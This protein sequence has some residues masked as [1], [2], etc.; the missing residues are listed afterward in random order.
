MLCTL[1][2][3]IYIKG[4]ARDYAGLGHGYDDPWKFLAMI[5]LYLAQINLFIFP[6]I[7]FF[8]VELVPICRNLLRRRRDLYLVLGLAALVFCI[9]TL[10]N[11]RLYL[12]M[13]CYTLLMGVI[14]AIGYYLG[15]SQIKDERETVLNA[16]SSMLQ[17]ADQLSQDVNS[18]NTELTE[19]GRTVTDLDVSTEVGHVRQSLLAHIKRIVWSNRK[20]PCVSSLPSSSPSP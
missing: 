1:P 20:R 12:I 13:F 16:L 17:S 15:R 6:F 9:I 19:I 14:F 2:F 10:S 7:L 4:W 11:A 3:F 18:H 8:L 5:K